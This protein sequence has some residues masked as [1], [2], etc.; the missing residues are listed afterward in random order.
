MRL[1]LALP[2]ALALGL[3]ACSSD[4]DGVDAAICDLPATT[5][6]CTVGDDTPCTAACA[7]AY[8]FA[9]GTGGGTGAG[10]VICTKNCTT[11]ADCPEGWSCNMVGRCR[12]P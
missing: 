6:A 3:A 1:A 7:S 8:C 2:L 4:D 12:N 10:D 5:I 11:A 9:F